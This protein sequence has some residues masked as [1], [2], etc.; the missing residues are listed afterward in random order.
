ME[1][2]ISMIQTMFLTGILFT[3][4]IIFC[5]VKYPAFRDFSRRFMMHAA[6]TFIICGLSFVLA[7]IYIV[8]PID[9]IPDPIPV[10]GQLDDLGVFAAAALTIPVRLIYS[11]KLL[12]AQKKKGKA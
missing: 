5:L 12:M 7:I 11:I 8:S 2:I 4:I 3:G 1:S 6:G 9:L 10:L